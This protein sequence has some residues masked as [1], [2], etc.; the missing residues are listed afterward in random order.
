MFRSHSAAWNPHLKLEFA[1]VCIRTVTE[2]LQADR[3]VRERSEEEFVDRE[4]EIAM[5][6][7]Q[8]NSTQDNEA[9][10]EYIEELRGKKSV[11]VEEKGRRLAEKLGTKWYNE[12]EK[13]TR[14]FLRLLNRS[15]PDDFTELENDNGEQIRG[16]DLIEAEIVN[17]YKSLYEGTTDSNFDVN[18]NNDFTFFDHLTEVDAHHRGDVTKDI[19]EAELLT[20]LGTCS[21]SA[22]GPDGIPYSYI[23]GLWQLLGPLLI[24]S[25]NYS[26]RSGNLAPSDKLSFLKLIPKAGKDLKKLTNWRPI[27]LSNCDHKLITK[28][29]AKRLSSA[30]DSCIGG[31]QTAYLKGRLISDNIRGLIGSVNLANLEDNIDGLIVSLDAKKAFDSVSHRFIEEVL[32]RFGM[33][34][35][36]PIFRVLYK[37]LKSDI[38]I[39]GRVTR[40]YQIKRG[41][42]QGDAL[43]CILFIMCIEPL[44]LNIEKNVRIRSLNSSELNST[45]PK[46]Y[47][48]A[49]DVSVVSQNQ[50]ESVQNIFDE[51]ARLTLLSGLELNASKT[52]L[53]RIKS[54]GNRG[55]PE[56]EF[57]VRY[58]NKVHLIKTTK[59]VKIN[60][61][62]LQQDPVEMRK[63]NLDAVRL[64]TE[65]NCKKWAGRRLCLLGKILILKTFGISQMIFIMQCMTLNDSDFKSLNAILYKFLWNRHFEAAKAPDRISRA[66][67]NLPIKLGGFGMLNIE[68]LDSGLKLKALGRMFGSRHPWLNLINSKLRLEEFFYP[69]LGTSLDLVAQKGIEL[70]GT[71]RRSIWEEEVINLEARSISL[72]RNIKLQSA[73]SNTG[74]NSLIY[75]NIRR[76]GCEKISQLDANSLAG[77]SRFL[78]RFLVNISRGLIN[79]NVNL[80]VSMLNKH[81]YLKKKLTELSS[82]SSKAIRDGRVQKDP[83]CVFKGGLINSPI[84][85]INWAYKVSKL[86]CTRL[87]DVLLRVAHR[88]FYTKEKL[89]RY[90]LKDSP[91]CPRCDHLE[92][93][94]HKTLNCTYVKKIWDETFRLTDKLYDSNGIDLRSKVMG[95]DVRSTLAVLTSHA[96]I[97]NK[98]L[99]LRDEATYI[100]RPKIFVRMTFET[101]IKKERN[102]MIKRDLKSIF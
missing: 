61:I 72:I 102:K 14:Y 93:Y 30:V 55:H 41:V 51:Y 11:L 73:V 39:N 70:L 95:T 63:A 18:V 37:D 58:L 2:K 43:S 82:C 74:K 56:I 49:D 50:E 80:D 33:G 94:D 21:D 52:E 36:V 87:K 6:A 4:I 89:H 31:R 91:N 40:G 15:S 1:K 66:T 25:W 48:Y 67:I 62:L 69:K 65:A 53:L 32:V 78:P 84:E 29:Y 68:E 83:I 100:I 28:T 12:G 101:L 59:S 54:G 77:L 23:A 9:I 10:I 86:S 27:T 46:S 90:N 71:D 8:N 85:T 75:F 22:P 38:I 26:L 81:T 98:I 16:D 97:L 17:Y 44:M 96:E 24:D 34:N 47:A 79:L 7:L 64:R 19:T 88:D 99:S 57:N 42:K 92:D 45:L 5:A 3:K 60:G 76:N 13:S 20:V 35:F